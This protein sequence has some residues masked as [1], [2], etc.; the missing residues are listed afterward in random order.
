MVKRFITGYLIC[1]DPK[2][3]TRTF[4]LYQSEKFKFNNDTLRFDQ[5]KSVRTDV[6]DLD[7]LVY[8]SVYYE[9]NCGFSTENSRQNFQNLMW[10]YDQTFNMEYF[11][12]VDNAVKFFTWR[13]IYRI[14]GAYVFYVLK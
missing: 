4:Y 10:F 14:N 8:E 6:N 2:I 1:A 5:L 9:L 7:S 12:F 11:D 13:E 3:F